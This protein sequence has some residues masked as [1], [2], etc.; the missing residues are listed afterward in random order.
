MLILPLLVKCILT[1]DNTCFVFQNSKLCDIIGATGDT[2]AAGAAGIG[3]PTILL[4]GTG[5]GN[6]PAVETCWKY[7]LSSSSLLLLNAI[8]IIIG[9]CY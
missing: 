9:N 8:P 6:P 7:I 2:G 1:H 3:N 4:E 5:I